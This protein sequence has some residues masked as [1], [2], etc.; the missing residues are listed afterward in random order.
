MRRPK[1]VCDVECSMNRFPIQLLVALAMLPGCGCEQATLTSAQEHEMPENSRQATSEPAA[2]D[3]IEPSHPDTRTEPETADDD[4]N[5]ESATG[6]PFFRGNP[7]STGIASTTLPDDL[8]ILWEIPVDK[9][10]FFGTPTLVQR[11]ID[12]VATQTVFIADADGTVYAIDLRAGEI[13]WQTK[14]AFSFDTAP[15]Y[16]NERLYLGDVDGKFICLNAETG[17]ELWTFETLAPINSSANFHGDNVIFGSQDSKLYAL[18][19]DS[20]ETV[21][22]L[23][24]GDQIRC[25]ITVAGDNAFV[26]GC[27][28]ALHII[29]LNCGE[30]TGS[31]SIDAPTGSTPA[32]AGDLLYVGS[33]GAGFFAI[34]LTEQKEAWFFEPAPGVGIRSSAA[35]NEEHVIF[36]AQNQMVYALE[37]AT[38]EKIWETSVTSKVDSSPVIVGDRVFV[39]GLDGRLYSL[40]ISDGMI[41][42]ETGFEGG[43]TGSPAVAFERLVIATDRGVVYC[44]G[45][46]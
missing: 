31:V 3:T 33:E 27:D 2:G 43:F 8:E 28:G 23:S 14:C 46:E 13:D 7:L 35:V 21:W 16:R 44:L 10:A 22:E 32:V 1:R 36:G 6:W 11:I 25:S 24:T 37:P 20:G 26:A 4:S 12:D 15:V 30:E 39:G 45:R 18:N 38:G 41:L 34:N 9:G 19:A 42:T 29:D 40:D 17:D 5:A